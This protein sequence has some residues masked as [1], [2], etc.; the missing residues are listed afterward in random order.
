MVDTQWESKVGRQRP[1][2]FTQSAKLTGNSYS[3]ASHEVGQ[4]CITVRLLLSNPVSSLLPFKAVKPLIN[5]LHPKLCLESAS[6]DPHLRRTSI[7][8]L[9]L[10]HRLLS[11]H[12]IQMFQVYF[13]TP[14]ISEGSAILPPKEPRRKSDLISYIQTQEGG[15]STTQFGANPITRG[16]VQWSLPVKP[17]IFSNLFS[18]SSLLRPQNCN[19]KNWFRKNPPT[20]VVWCLDHGFLSKFRS[21]NVYF[22]SV[23]G[24]PTPLPPYDGWIMFSSLG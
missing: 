14:W 12:L 18:N 21:K 3:K 22:F 20:H 19:F 4:G 8:L 7:N 23:L 10:P 24:Q 15:I 2:H 13:P 11:K 5:I 1:S 17:F 6:G 16:K 9:S